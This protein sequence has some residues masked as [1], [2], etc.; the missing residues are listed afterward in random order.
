MRSKRSRLISLV[1][2]P[3]QT[4]AWFK[5]VV[6]SYRKLGE[7]RADK[8]WFEDGTESVVLNAAIKWVVNCWRWSWSCLLTMGLGFW[9][10]RGQGKVK[11]N[12]VKQCL[13]SR[14]KSAVWKLQAGNGCER[15]CGHQ[16]KKQENAAD[17]DKNNGCS[18][19]LQNAEVIKP[20]ITSVS[21]MLGRC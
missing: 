5:K 21:S 2:L 19:T 12:L 4:G 14:R 9:M 18:G 17:T 7:I 11:R 6:Y 15:K 8:L 1:Q 3:H 10:L 13:R 20:V 16:D